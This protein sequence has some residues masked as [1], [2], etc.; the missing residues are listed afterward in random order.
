VGN[1][2]SVL[3]PVVV[4]RRVD[5]VRGVSSSSEDRTTALA[6]MGAVFVGAVFV[7]AVFVGAVFVGAV[8]VGA[9]FVGAVFV[10]AVFAD[11]VFVGA[12]FADA[13]FVGAV[14]ADAAFFCVVVDVAFVALVA[15]DGRALGGAP[16]V[17]FDGAGVWGGFLARVFFD[18]MRRRY[19]RLIAVRQQAAGARN[20]PFSHSAAPDERGDTGSSF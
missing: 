17:V 1:A 20:A 11:A 9:V 13:V 2:D 12:V 8:F 6:S 3:A 4:A 16:L 5:V 19:H 10:G 14:F 15:F 7:G 18:T